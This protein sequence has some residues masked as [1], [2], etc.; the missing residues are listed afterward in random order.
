MDDLLKSCLRDIFHL[1]MVAVEQCADV[2]GISELSFSD[3]INRF[4]PLRDQQQ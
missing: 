1:N 4:G 3:V 2:T